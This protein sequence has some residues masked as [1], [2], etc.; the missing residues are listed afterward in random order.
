MFET[1]LQCQRQKHGEL[2]EE[3][4]AALHNVGLVHLRAERH[5]E[6]L[7]AFEWA[8]RVRKGALGR[9]H[10][11]VAVSIMELDQ[12]FLQCARADIPF[13]VHSAGIFG[14]S[15]HYTLAPASV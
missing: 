2:H 4:G 7:E 1:V 10:P 14:E 9:D 3:V 11:D 5:T 12:S 8:V 13:F 6:A 15:G